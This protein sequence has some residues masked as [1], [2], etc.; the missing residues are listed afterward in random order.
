M[1]ATIM[2]AA[3]WMISCSDGTQ[4][5]GVDGSSISGGD[6]KAKKKTKNKKG[7][8][9]VELDD[10]ENVINIAGFDTPGSV[11]DNGEGGAPIEYPNMDFLGNGI[12]TCKGDSLP[13]KVQFFSKLYQDKLELNMYAA[14]IKAD[15]GKAED[16]ANEKI[17]QNTGITRY[18]RPGKLEIAKLKADGFKFATYAIFSKA[19]TKE[20]QGQ[21]YNFDKPLPVFP[22]PA[23]S[24]R[25][26]DLE[27]SGPQSWTAAV[28]GADNFTVTVTLSVVSISG[29]ETK[30]KLQTEIL[31]DQPG[32]PNHRARYEAFPIP[33]EAVYTVNGSTRDVRMIE[34]V[35]W[36][37]GDECKNR[38]EQITMTYRICRKSTSEKDEQFPCQ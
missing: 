19:V 36:F 26:E 17:N 31:E 21:T 7:E 33:R 14:S 5:V 34:N 27:K 18:D 1:V 32:D 10:T 20:R 3:A 6:S 2:V 4:V 23:P 28:T 8:D 24:S 29:D 37:K 30:L 25:Y 22:W 38:P 12:T 11:E 16:Q 13:T 15:K 9:G 35:S